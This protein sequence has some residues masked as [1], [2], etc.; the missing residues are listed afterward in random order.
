MTQSISV[1][2]LSELSDFFE[3]I[4]MSF[5][6][7]KIDDKIGNLP[8]QDSSF[9]ILKMKAMS[10][11]VTTKYQ[12]FVFNID[13]SGSMSDLC[14]DGHTKMQHIIHTVKNMVYYFNDNPSINANITIFIFD[15]NV[16]KILDRTCVTTE[17]IFD[18]VSIIDNI[19]PLSSTNIEAALKNS[20]EYIGRLKNSYPDNE[21]S[22][23]FMTDG[24]ASSGS[25]NHNVLKH[26]V[27]RSVLNAFIGFGIEHDS[28]LL[29]SL[30]R[31]SN[32]SYHFIDKLETAGFVYGE[33]LHGILYKSLKNVCLEIKDGL[34]YNYK[35]NLWTDML[36]IGDVIG[37]SDKTYHIISNNP[38]DCTITITGKSYKEETS[39][40][41][42]RSL[43]LFHDKNG[44]DNG[45]D[46]LVTRY[47]FRQRTLQLLFQVNEFESEKDR[48]YSFD[49]DKYSHLNSILNSGFNIC[50]NNYNNE[51]INN[52]ECH[53]KNKLKEFITEMKT[54]ISENNLEDDCFFKNLCDDIYI[55]YRTMG[56]KYGKM[57]TSARHSSQGGQRCYNVTQPPIPILRRQVAYDDRTI[58]LETLDIPND[59]LFH[60][61]S[62][63]AD[64]PYS[65]PQATQVMRAVSGNIWDDY[66]IKTQE[67]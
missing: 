25:K 62:N 16:H 64:T 50:V 8:I 9:G 38:Y 46:N 47:I 41:E 57:Y 33:I 45:N 48:K 54:Y 3:E 63:F 56:S 20:K 52:E 29:N 27:D 2:N 58:N 14:S 6:H 13:N 55:S 42:L 19:R 15:D 61:I 1:N 22:H 65:T 17:N 31:D 18:I 4:V 66:N 39:F 30:G 36:F 11:H 7:S 67:L 51:E 44:N 49:D 34:V 43:I 10:N 59:E 40:S 12:D 53:L 60:E 35:S 26:H 24:Y 23:I 37:E 5:D 32:C 28:C 21:I